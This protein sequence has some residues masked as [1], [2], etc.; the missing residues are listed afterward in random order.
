MKQV[1]WIIPDELAGRCGPE[2][3][4]WDC[5]DLNAGGIRA[6]AS[7]TQPEDEGEVRRAEIEHLPLYF[8]GM[9]LTDDE[10]FEFFLSF[11]PRFLDFA[12]RAREQ[13]KPLMVHCTYGCDR[14]GA[15][16]AIYLVAFHG[17]SSE[18]AISKVRSVNSEAMSAT[19]YDE[20]VRRY[21]LA[22]KRIPR[23]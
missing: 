2:L 20:A 1:Y 9:L 22:L 8:P 5:W 18:E 17:L 15:M 7:L 23:G 16:L 11:V 13:G 3:I 19:G 21:E 14:T 10:D 12:A 6:M 4:P